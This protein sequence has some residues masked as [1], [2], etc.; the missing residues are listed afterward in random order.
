MT[1]L[2]SLNPEARWSAKQCLESKV[3]DTVRNDYLEQDA[4]FSIMVPA[5][6]LTAKDLDSV[7]KCRTLILQEIILTK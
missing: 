5:D 3:F 7:E 1:G 6:S 4:P 2:L